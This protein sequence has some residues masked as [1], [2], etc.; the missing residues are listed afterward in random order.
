[1]YDQTTLLY[2]AVGYKHTTKQVWQ[3]CKIGVA[4]CRQFGGSFASGRVA[5]IVRFSRFREIVFFRIRPIPRF[6]AKRFACIYHATENLSIRRI[7]VKQILSK[8]S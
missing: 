2:S 7:S 6:S 1:M 8:I 5:E 3:F 4:V